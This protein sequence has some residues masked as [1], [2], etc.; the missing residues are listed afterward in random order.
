MTRR[1]PM[2][3]FWDTVR[4]ARELVA[5]DTA[6]PPTATATSSPDAPDIVA[7]LRQLD[8]VRADAR[9]MV[10]R[11][12]SLSAGAAIVPI[13]GFDIGTD[14]TILV[15][16]LPR[17]NEKFGLAPEQIEALDADTKRA[18]MMF[19]S[20]VG[21]KLIGRIV[22]RDVVLKILMKLGVRVTT[23]GIVKFVPL[24]G[25]ALSA[26]LSFGAMRLLGNQHVDDCYEVARRS[27]LDGLR[28]KPGDPHWEVV[29]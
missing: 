15:R 18:V 22:T 24:V 4:R 17:I 9:A 10:T 13:P 26:S 7:A 25:Q 29:A 20:A 8:R 12:A 11:R 3:I 1:T 27:L 28:Q 5:S 19:V 21:S 6:P 23:K 14:V 2:S 16:L